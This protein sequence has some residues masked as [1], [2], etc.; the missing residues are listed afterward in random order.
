M[1]LKNYDYLY[2][3]STKNK[4]RVLQPLDKT[5]K[6]LADTHICASPLMGIAVLLG[7]RLKENQGYLEDDN[8]K[9]S[10]IL[11]ENLT[12]PEIYLYTVPAAGFQ[13]LD[14]ESDFI[15]VTRSPVVCLDKQNISDP[16][17]FTKEKGIIIKKEF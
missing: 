17:L 5:S 4:L 3:G 13:R 12:F 6:S 9:I 8:G 14:P 1:K 2:V 10:L 7:L 16:L 15:W 11:K